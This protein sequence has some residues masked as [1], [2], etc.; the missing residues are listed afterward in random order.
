MLQPL[1]QGP[2]DD[3]SALYTI[4]FAE[5]GIIKAMIVFCSMAAIRQVFSKQ[6]KRCV[7]SV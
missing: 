5:S 7:R 1:F 3:C 4:L 2:F 6:E